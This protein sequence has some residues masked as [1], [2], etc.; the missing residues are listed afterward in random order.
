VLTAQDVIESTHLDRDVAKYSAD[1]PVR[2]TLII[3]AAGE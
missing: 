3:E 1:P 2:L